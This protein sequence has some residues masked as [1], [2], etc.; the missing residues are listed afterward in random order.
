MW[1][2][3]ASNLELYQLGLP[4]CNREA[5]DDGLVKESLKGQ[6]RV[7]G[8]LEGQTGRAQKSCP[9]TGPQRK[10]SGCYP[11]V[12]SISLHSL[13]AFGADACQ[14]VVTKTGQSS[15]IVIHRCLLLVMMTDLGIY[16]ELYG[17]SLF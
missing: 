3:D 7:T 10:I 9:Q 4:N 16:E 15:D 5:H 8:L 13:C 2:P 6:G 14:T 17:Y 11:T 1:Q 12:V